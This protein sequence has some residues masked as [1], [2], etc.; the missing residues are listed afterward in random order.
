MTVVPLFPIP[1]KTVQTMVKCELWTEVAVRKVRIT[2]ETKVREMKTVFSA[3]EGYRSKQAQALIVQQQTSVAQKQ[4]SLRDEGSDD[5]NDTN[6]S[7]NSNNN[8]RMKMIC[9]VSA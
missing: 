4:T 7:N 3:Y 2:S 9:C 5:D 6:S 8:G 1:Q